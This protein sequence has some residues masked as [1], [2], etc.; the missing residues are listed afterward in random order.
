MFLA[1]LC[2]NIR[3]Y[4]VRILHFPT[5]VR[6]LL[7]L[8]IGLPVRSRAGFD[9]G[10]SPGPEHVD[11]EIRCVVGL[12]SGV[13][14]D[15]RRG[16]NLPA[17]CEL[18]G[19]VILRRPSFRLSECAEECRMR[20]PRGCDWTMFKGCDGSFFFQPPL[21]LLSFFL[22]SLPLL[23]CGIFLLACSPVLFVLSLLLPLPLFREPRILRT[24]TPR[25]VASRVR[26]Y[27]ENLKLA[28][29]LWGIVHR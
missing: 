14:V 11:L 26:K 20:I 19:Q 6:Q 17:A 12:M 24:R 21:F 16:R 23:P 29:D 15:H 3:N 8:A 18:S 5:D 27:F 1:R 2:Q 13:A 28:C 22:F 25:R 7:F 10:C 9:A 4:H